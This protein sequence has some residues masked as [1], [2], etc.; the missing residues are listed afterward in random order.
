M[1]DQGYEVSS[2]CLR[3]CRDPAASLIEQAAL[4]GQVFSNLALELFEQAPRPRTSSSSGNQPWG[5]GRFWRRSE[6]LMFLVLANV[7]EL[8]QS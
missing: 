3:R 8:D 2:R 4:V 6:A 5:T 7:G 1:V